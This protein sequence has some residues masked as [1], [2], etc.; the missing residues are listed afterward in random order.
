MINTQL[1]L[2]PGDQD[3]FEG[4]GWDPDGVTLTWKL[5]LNRGP[6]FYVGEGDSFTATWD[7]EE[8]DIAEAALVSIRLSGERAYHRLANG[9]DDRVVFQYSV[10]PRPA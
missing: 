7:V 2:R 6:T 3:T 4:R 8:A 1:I 9:D 10:L 5:G